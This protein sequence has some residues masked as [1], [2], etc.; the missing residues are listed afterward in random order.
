MTNRKSYGQFCGL[1][2]ALDHI[3]D[4]WTLLIVREL[5]I[6]PR[7]FRELQAALNGVSPN[8][9]VERL[10]LLV[11]DGIVERNEAPPRSPAVSF[12]LSE[13]GAA[14][15][16]VVL[17]LIRWGARWMVSGP[18][19]DRVDARWSVLALRALLGE[20]RAPGLEDGCIHLDVDG[21][22]VTVEIRDNVRHIKLGLAGEPNATCSISMPSLLA[23]AS[24]MRRL[25]DVTADIRGSRDL[26]EV[27]LAPEPS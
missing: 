8:L 4:R 27:A 18:G 15:E 24:G 6:G 16:S 5:L 13:T 2:R 14:L 26:V 22:G 12:S 3:G 9:L 25:T 10:G 1:A 21:D 20:S 19:S 11:K 23:V 17:E 7:T